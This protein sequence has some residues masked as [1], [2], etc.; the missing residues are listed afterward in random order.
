MSVENN[1]GFKLD[2]K[3]FKIE[4]KYSE[5][6]EKKEL[7]KLTPKKGKSI[8][9][10]ADA[11]LGIIASQFKTKEFALALADT[12]VDKIYLVEAIRQIYF[13]ADKD[14]KKGDKIHLKFPHMYP[15]VLAALEETYNICKMN[16]DVQSVPVEIYKQVL[17]K[18]GEINRPF[19]EKFY[20]EQIK[21][22]S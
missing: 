16:G 20:K 18:L 7:I 11:L 2:N 1:K 22:T 6:A 17:E 4:V 10:N 19:I 9:I 3:D 5:E 21:K 8:E 15:Y 14:Y 13:D 12:E